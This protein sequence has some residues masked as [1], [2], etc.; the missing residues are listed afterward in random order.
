M[1]R[2]KKALLVLLAGFFAF[3]PPG[4][5]IFLFI[6]AVGVFRNRPYVVAGILAAACAVAVWLIWRR[7][8]ARRA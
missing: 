3:A 8:S 5:L 2:I 4:T 1:K 6:L 7:R